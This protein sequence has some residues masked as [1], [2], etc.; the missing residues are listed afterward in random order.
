[1]KLAS[2]QSFLVSIFIIYLKYASCM[3]YAL[4]YHS[5]ELVKSRCSAVKIIIIIYYIN[6]YY[7]I[8]FSEAGKTGNPLSDAETH[9]NLVNELN[10]QVQ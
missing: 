3:F 1:M 4:F 7:T 8:T 6:T 5:K 10:K 2:Q 9:V